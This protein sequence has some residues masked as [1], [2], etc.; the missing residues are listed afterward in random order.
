VKPIFPED[1]ISHTCGVIRTRAS[2]QRAELGAFGLQSL[3]DGSDDLGVVGWGVGGEAGEDG[4]VFADEKLFEVPEELG[5]GVGWGK[6]VGGGV[7]GEVFAPGA[8][9]YVGGG[10]GDER[11]VEGVFAG[12]GDGDLGEE[13]EGD[14]VV[15]GAEL[16]DLLIGAGLLAGEVVGGEAEDDE[17]AVFVLLVEGFEGGVLG[18]EAA[19]GGDVHDEEGVAG[20]VG[21]GGGG[22]GEGGE[23]DVVE[24][25]HAGSVAR[26]GGEG[27]RGKHGWRVVAVFAPLE[28]CG[29]LRRCDPRG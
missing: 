11:G 10:G 16:G 27:E 24:S 21:E 14:G 17:A 2:S 20:V 4:A 5:K 19:L 7:A 29:V 8:V 3:F 13:G 12:A 1:L 22:A 25:R 26:G 18:G 28:E 6:V 9:G 15:G 23:G